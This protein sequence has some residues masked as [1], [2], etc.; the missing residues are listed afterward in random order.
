MDA[1]DD[2]KLNG[3]YW[4]SS[5]CG[6]CRIVSPPYL[7]S[8]EDID[9]DLVKTSKAYLYHTTVRMARI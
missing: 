8:S 7:P 1:C 9:I 2:N 6:G 3:G 4:V 5:L